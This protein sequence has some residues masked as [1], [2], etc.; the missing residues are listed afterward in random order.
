MYLFFSSNC[1]F[2]VGWDVLYGY[3][4]YFVRSVSLDLYVNRFG[5]FLDYGGSIR[6][7]GLY[8]NFLLCL[9]WSYGGVSRES[10]FVSNR[11]LRYEYSGSVLLFYFMYIFEVLLFVLRKYER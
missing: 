11:L 1:V 7:F 8:D 4:K 6:F 2:L 3:D 10:F 5:Y 9:G